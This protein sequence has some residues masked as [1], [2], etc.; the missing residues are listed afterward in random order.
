M[1]QFQWYEWYLCTDYLSKFSVTKYITGEIFKNT[2]YEISPIL[3]FTIQLY[4][5]TKWIQNLYYRDPLPNN[6]YNMVDFTKK[7]TKLVNLTDSELCP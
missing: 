6:Q 4:T 1:S 7:E 5:E 3:N 2:D